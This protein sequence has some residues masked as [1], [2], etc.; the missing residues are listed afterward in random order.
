M[1]LI[2][3]LIAAAGALGLGIFVFA[4][5]ARSFVHRIFAV[6]ML[7]LAA[8][9]V[10]TGLLMQA[11]TFLEV[12]RWLY[13]KILTSAF[14]PGVWLLFSLTY[15]RANYREFLVRW[16]WVALTLLAF[17]AAIAIFLK[18]SFFTDAPILL[19]TTWLWR[20]GYS[21]YIFYLLLLLGSVL[22]LTNLEKTLRT[23][24]GQFR[25]QIKFLIFGVASLFGVR[26]YT[27]S[28]TVLFRAFDPST[29]ILHSAVLVVA[30]L[31]IAR[32]LLRSRMLNVNFYLSE[33]ALYNSFTVLLVGV[34][35]ILVGIVAK[36]AVY[37]RLS[38]AAAIQTFVLFLAILGLCVVLLSDRFR[39]RLK[40]FI[41]RHFRRPVYDYRKEWAKF[42]GVTTSVAREK[43][44][45]PAVARTVSTTLDVL[46]V[47]IWIMDEKTESLVL[48]GS[49]A[50]SEGDSDAHGAIRQGMTN[51]FHIIEREQL[52]PDFDYSKEHM[53]RFADWPDQEFFKAARISYAIPLVAG[54]QALGL[55]TVGSKVGTDAY[56][57]EDF[58]LLKTVADQTAASLLNLKLSGQLQQ[59][60]EL[61]ALRTMSAF[62][63]HDLK[64]VASK[65]SLTVQNMPIHFN[66]PEFRADALQSISQSLE[67]ING[68]CN[69]LTSLSQRLEIEPA[70]HDVNELIRT[71]STGFEGSTGVRIVQN[72]GDLPPVM[73][74]GEQVQKVVL[75]LILNAHDALS[76][77]GEITIGTRQR[78]GWVEVTVH[79][80]GCGMSREFME[81]S[82]FQP[83][84]TTKRKGMGIGLYHSKM[85]VEAHKGKIE[86]E[87]E[88]GRGT[89]FR[90]L[91]PLK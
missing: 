72:L 3:S 23:S 13:L 84:K 46:A 37:F 20:L 61:E 31:L 17:P 83:F 15:S 69:R 34:Y 21:G 40:Y 79:D 56:T 19:Q 9:A 43:D 25:W 67:K 52:P 50:L 35:L 47:S 36:I 87:S 29:H 41:S 63:I 54:G 51:L 32:S 64:N 81:K 48:S 4:R 68:M 6:G 66:N 86:V 73:V 62:F 16:R 71:T 30:C 70:P 1:E 74:D 49:T 55:L 60:K 12:G 65:L 77:G 10:F 24:T 82:L 38:Q 76:N 45:C 89:T 28:Q 27:L 91:L 22:I 44:L 53:A 42:T 11:G 85:I 5:D 26:I 59:A 58:D 90:V 39:K 8:D 33:S 2:L 88:E 80:N 78:K 18:G 7:L 75:N 57:H 14:I